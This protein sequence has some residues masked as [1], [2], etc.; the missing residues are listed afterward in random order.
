MADALG[1]FVPVF[2][3]TSVIALAGAVIC[4]LFIKDFDVEQL[5]TK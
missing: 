1:S 4:V 2:I 3:M 5:K